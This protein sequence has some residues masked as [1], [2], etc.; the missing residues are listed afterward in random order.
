MIT[1]S[2]RQARQ[3]ML[4]KHGLL[5]EY[6][7]VGKQGAL[8]FIHQ[9]GCIQFDPVDSC[10]K[11]AELTLQSR[12]KGFTKQTLNELLYIDRRLVDYPDKN[13]SIIPVEN[14]PYF[15]RYRQSAKESGLR[16]D[17]LAELE[18]QA[19][20]YLKTNSP[21]NSDELPIS[22][23]IHW[24]SSIHWSGGWNGN[25]NAARAV[26]EQ[27]YST[28]ELVIHHK[29]GTRKYYDLAKKYIPAELLIADDP[30]PDE[31]EHQKWRVL[32]RIG[33]VGLLWNRPSD[34]WLN[35]WG[36]KSRQRNEVFKELLDEGKILEIKVEDLKD[37]LFCR[38]EDLSL[39]ETVLQKDKFKPRCELIAPLDCMMWDRK[40][41]RALFGF[42][43]TWEI[44]TPADKRKYGFYV[45]PLLY[46]DNFIGRLESVA[47]KKTSTLTV[48]NIWYEDS[49]KQNN[50]I[51]TAIEKCIKRFA[52]FNECNK[53][54]TN[55]PD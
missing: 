45:L 38:A 49:V 8:D 37:N 40:L 15:A 33:A 11:N 50:I 1:L 25:T 24:H 52:K 7:F 48:K 51:R 20:D 14:W 13:L 4:L 43:Y 26:L 3:L 27:L 39:I 23:S 46:C 53:I 54:N 16:F 22:G 9:V 31:F 18:A 17:G 34:A 28:G 21:V 35:I 5:G 6:K 44:Y 42:D 19:I 2:N 36:L 55:G 41:I 12:V 10:G 29:N 30:L 32:R 47:N